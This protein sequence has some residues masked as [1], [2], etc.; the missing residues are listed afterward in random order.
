M[1]LNS[2]VPYMSVWMDQMRFSNLDG[3]PIFENILKI[4]SRLARS[5]ALVR[6]KK[7]MCNGL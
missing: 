1:F 3:Q 7:A 4:P 6:S 2:K 5:N